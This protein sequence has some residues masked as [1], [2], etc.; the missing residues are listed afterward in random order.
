MLQASVVTLQPSQGWIQHGKSGGVVRRG[1][2]GRERACPEGARD[3][4]R[5]PKIRPEGR[6]PQAKI[7]G[8]TVFLTPFPIIL[9]LKQ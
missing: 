9:D 1:P 4:H 7:L 8:K 2:K 5:R 3:D 6:P